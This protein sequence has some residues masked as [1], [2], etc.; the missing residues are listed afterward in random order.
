MVRRGAVPG[1]D[2][3]VRAAGP[4]LACATVKREPL[5]AT[6]KVGIQAHR[7][8]VRLPTC[9]R[10]CRASLSII[11]AFFFLWMVRAG[12]EQGM[13]PAEAYSLSG[14]IFVAI[15]LTATVWAIIV[16]TFIDRIN[17][18]L[19][20]AVGSALACASY[21]LFG[22]VDDPFQPIMY[23]AAVFWRRRD[24]RYPRLAGADRAGRAT[25]GARRSDRRVHLCGRS[26]SFSPPSSVATCS[27]CGGVG[28]LCGHGQHQRVTIVATYTWVKTRPTAAMLAAGA[29]LTA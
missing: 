3:I 8:K 24:E 18:V 1:A 6:L 7:L 4:R 5:L 19:T 12:K 29:D 9:R 26:A 22:L 23:A 16:I 10:P 17:R 2:G 27:T 15:Q 14:G 11:S 13:T 21:T 25:E 20:M 28:A